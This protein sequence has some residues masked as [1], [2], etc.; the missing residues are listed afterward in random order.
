MLAPSS[1][2]DDCFDIILLAIR[3][4]NSVDWRCS[5]AGA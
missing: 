4:L 3:V 1:I 5:S 2:Q